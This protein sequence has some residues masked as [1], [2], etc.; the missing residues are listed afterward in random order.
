MRKNWSKTGRICEPRRN[1]LDP[2]RVSKFVLISETVLQFGGIRYD[3][4][5][6]VDNIFLRMHLAKKSAEEVTVYENAQQN[7]IETSE[8]SSDDEPAYE[9][10]IDQTQ[11]E[12]N[13]AA[14]LLPQ[15]QSDSEE[16]S[17]DLLARRHK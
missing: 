3:N 9:Q 13:P 12:R 15:Q 17:E 7:V 14:A 10:D 6:P 5:P 4:N 1:A 8:S 16:E 2:V 11:P